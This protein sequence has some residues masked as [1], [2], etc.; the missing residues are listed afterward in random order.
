M[1]KLRLLP[2][3]SL[4]LCLCAAAPARCDDTRRAGEFYF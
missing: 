2:C 3:V 1:T 4:L